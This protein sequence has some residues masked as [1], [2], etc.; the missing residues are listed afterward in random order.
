MRKR[1]ELV[2]SGEVARILDCGRQSAWKQ[3][4][5]GRIPTAKR[6]T[7]GCWVADRRA[8]IRLKRDREGSAN[9]A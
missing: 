6:V 4:R 2:G 1:E 5:S 7:G 8:V 9:A 3:L